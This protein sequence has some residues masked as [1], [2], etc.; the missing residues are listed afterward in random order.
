VR[1]DDPSIRGVG[2]IIDGDFAAED[3]ALTACEVEVGA[4]R[5]WISPADLTR[6]TPDE[7]ARLC[8]VALARGLVTSERRARLDDALRE[9]RAGKRMVIRT[10]GLVD[11]LWTTSTLADPTHGSGAV[12]TFLTEE[13]R[14]PEPAQTRAAPP[15]QPLP[16]L[17]EATRIAPFLGM[18]PGLVPLDPAQL[19][20]K[21]VL[22]QILA[23]VD[24]DRLVDLV[25]RL[26][27]GSMQA[28]T[29]RLREALL[30]RVSIELLDHLLTI[31]TDYEL[32]YVCWR[33]GA[34]LGTSRDRATLRACIENVAALPPD[35]AP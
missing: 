29:P 24:R 14:T 6:I 19:S 10:P 22:R 32:L 15:P 17:R 13:A 2:K 21:E 4:R 23:T 33:L 11:L 26:K 7:E 27:A 5:V 30:A 31:L 12:T 16:A 25:A 20:S 34:R 1:G 9:F 8:D 35:D 28:D 3:D 18:P